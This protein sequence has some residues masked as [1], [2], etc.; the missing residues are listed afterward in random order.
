[1]RQ[2]LGLAVLASTWLVLGSGCGYSTGRLLREDIHTVYV[3]MFENH[4]W[5]RGLEVELTRAVVREVELRTRLRFAPRE[6]ADSILEGALVDLERAAPV[7]D[8]EDRIL[9]RELAATVRFR[10]V[11]N[12]TGEEIV[13]RQTLVERRKFALA[14]AEPLEAFLFRE[15]AEQL[16]ERMERSW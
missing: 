4:T 5:E 10:W 13:P 7:K 16:V 6:E 14:R 9:L 3:P 8:E 15:V 11:D 2:V 1:L 12:L